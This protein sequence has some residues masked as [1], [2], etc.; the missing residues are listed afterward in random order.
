MASTSSYA[1]V[2]LLKP[3]TKPSEDTVSQT[4]S[5]STK[6]LHLA[7]KLAGIYWKELVLVVSNNFPEK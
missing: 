2:N 3:S 4:E 5:P 7:E 1:I 6:A